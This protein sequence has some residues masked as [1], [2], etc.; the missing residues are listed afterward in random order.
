MATS[1]K[2]NE[3]GKW[4]V[5]YPNI[6]TQY[7][8]CV[9]RYDVTCY[10][11]LYLAVYPVVRMVRIQNDWIFVFI[12]FQPCILWYRIFL[13]SFYVCLLC[14]CPFTLLFFLSDISDSY[15]HYGANSNENI[16]IKSF[17]HFYGNKTFVIFLFFAFFPSY[18]QLSVIFHLIKNEFCA[19]KPMRRKTCISVHRSVPI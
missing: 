19:M 8:I 13:S 12:E 3:W 2:R 4:K 7:L 15:R 14:L 11:P 1:A 6:H 10:Q 16:S 18:L 9:K 5:H 17:S